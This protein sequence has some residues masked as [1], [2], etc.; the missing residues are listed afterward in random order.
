MLNITRRTLAQ[1][2]GFMKVL[3]WN[4][5]ALLAGAILL[6]VSEII[7]DLVLTPGV[8]SADR[9]AT[10]FIIKHMGVF[11]CFLFANYKAFQPSTGKKWVKVIIVALVLTVLFIVLTGALFLL[12]YMLAGD[13]YI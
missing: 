1:P 8:I 12:A 11:G 10:L 13:G 2:L 4:L 6:F 9:G 5:L 7:I 3:K